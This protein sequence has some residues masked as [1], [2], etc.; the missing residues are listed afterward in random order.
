MLSVTFQLQITSV[1]SKSVGRTKR[2]KEGV[3]CYLKLLMIRDCRSSKQSFQLNQLGLESACI[4][5]LAKS[6]GVKCIRIGLQTVNINVMIKVLQSIEPWFLAI[7]D[8]SYSTDRLVGGV[9]SQK[10]QQVLI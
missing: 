3:G 6:N 2:R 8:A 7:K 9:E 4:E 10:P 5:L 1:F